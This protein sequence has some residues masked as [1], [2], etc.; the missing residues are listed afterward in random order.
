MHGGVHAGG[1]YRVPHIEIACL[2]VYTNTV[3]AGHMRAPGAPQTL[4]AVESHMDMIAHELG[5]DPI[6]FRLR[7]VL[8]EGDASPLGERWRHI[9]GKETLLAAAQAAGWGT[10]K[11]PYVG[12][13]IGATLDQISG[14]RQRAP[15][16]RVDCNPNG[17]RKLLEP[18]PSGGHAQFP[19]ASLDA[20][21]KQGLS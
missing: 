6:E 4:F 10:E 11:A 15:E 21:E 8:A 17:V 20:L 9:R 18:G 3:P 1:S 16:G 19:C 2:R 14:G 12:R 13:G 5:L 7:N